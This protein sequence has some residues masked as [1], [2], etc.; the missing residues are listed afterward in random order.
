MLLRRMLIMLGVVLVVV[1]AL[2]AYKGFSIY[3]Q[4]QMF[5]APQPAISVSAA[6]AEEQPWQGRL[7]AIG[8]L[9]AFQGVDLA[10]EVDGIVSAVL[11]ESG[12]KVTLGQPLIQ[13]DSEVERANLATAEAVRSLARVEFERGRSLVSRQNIS[14][15][16][17]DRLNA[18]L[19]KAEA[20]VSQLKAQ[21]DKKRVLAPFAGTIGIRQVDT[22][23][24]LSPGAAIATLQDLSRL[25]VDF[26]LPE[27]RAPQ[28]QVGQ[29]VLVGVAAYPGETFEGQIAAIN[30]KVENE[31]RNLQVRATLS[32]PDEKLLPGMFANLEVLLPGDEAKI[33]VPE[34]AITYTLYGNSVYVIDEKRGEDGQ[35]VKDE[36]GKTQLTV[37]R[38]FVETGERRAG[39]VVIVKG[40]Q[41]GEQVVTSGQLKLD[42]GAHVEVVEDPALAIQAAATTQ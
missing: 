16:E 6:L 19:L 2:A 11:F 7:P 15:S 5:S 38:R 27:Q 41:A 10:A 3:Q 20:T 22:G 13:L 8:T 9:K 24:Y 40:L 34:T 33:V 25:H 42:N 23:D 28:L 26:F 29:R 35:P 17:F 30:P 14:K 32:N 39:R 4:I 18:E 21:L 12:Q 31:T 37:E 36:G 1:L